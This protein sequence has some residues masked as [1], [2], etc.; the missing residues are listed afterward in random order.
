MMAQQGIRDG[1]SDG[2]SKAQTHTAYTSAHLK[3]A[4]STL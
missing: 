1:K 3:T 2:N 4:E